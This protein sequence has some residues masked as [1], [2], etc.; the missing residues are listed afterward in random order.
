MLRR[1]MGLR[2][3]QK[4]RRPECPDR[5]TLDIG[6][7][8]QS[9]SGTAPAPPHRLACR[10]RQAFFTARWRKAATARSGS[11]SRRIAQLFIITT[12]FAPCHGTG[13]QVEI[14]NRLKHRQKLGLAGQKS[15]DWK[16]IA[17]LKL[18]SGTGLLSS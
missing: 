2:T 5:Y 15:P 7:V 16:L 11:T 4:R 9:A 6:A 13:K 10:D 3:G 17:T 8:Q 12:F 14:N 1:F 18:I